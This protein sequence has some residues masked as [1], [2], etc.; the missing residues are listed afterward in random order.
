MSNSEIGKII[1]TF[2]Q[3]TGDHSNDDQ[4][5][6]KEWDATFYEELNELY[7]VVVLVCRPYQINVT[8]NAIRE[9]TY[10]IQLEANPTE[11]DQIQEKLTLYLFT[12]IKHITDK[13]FLTK[14]RHGYEADRTQK[15]PELFFPEED[16]PEGND[17]T[18]EK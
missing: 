8:N 3:E 12:Q 10:V 1:Y 14:M 17:N 18:L 13:A 9:G 6:E 4:K 11:L 2:Q 7:E 15:I 5:K 16:S